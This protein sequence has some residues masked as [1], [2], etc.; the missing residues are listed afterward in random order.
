MWCV[1]NGEPRKQLG[2]IF[3]DMCSRIT[4]EVNEL[5]Y[6]ENMCWAA[7]NTTASYAHVTFHFVS[8]IH[9]MWPSP[10]SLLAYYES[11]N[12][13]VPLVVLLLAAA[14]PSSIEDIISDRG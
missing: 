13:E 12:T 14:Y 10:Q 6:S 8:S 11:L 9:K 7:L 1:H 3:S 2:T 4:F 5:A